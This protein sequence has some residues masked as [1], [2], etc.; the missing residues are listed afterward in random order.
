[1]SQDRPQLDPL[2]LRRFLG[3]SAQLIA[4]MNANPGATSLTDYSGKG[5]PLTP[6][7]V[8]FGGRPLAPGL[9][10]KS[11]RFNGVSSKLYTSVFDTAVP[12]PQSAG[13]TALF[14]INEFFPV[15]TRGCLLNAQGAG[16]EYFRIR[17]F[18]NVGPLVETIYNDGSGEAYGKS[19]EGN[20]TGMPSLIAVR[21]NPDTDELAPVIVS[22]AGEFF[23]PPNVG[24]MSGKLPFSPVNS[25]DFGAQRSGVF[26]S[27]TMNGLAI[28]SRFVTNEELSLI[29]DLSGIKNP[30]ADYKPFYVSDYPTSPRRYFA[31]Y[32]TDY[33]DAIGKPAV[34]VWPKR[35]FGRAT[36]RG[37]LGA[38]DGA[39]VGTASGGDAPSVDDYGRGLSSGSGGQVTVPSDLE[40]NPSSPH[41][42]IAT[43]TA[44]S[45]GFN[46]FKQRIDT[47]EDRV[48]RIVDQGDGSFSA[49][50]VINEGGTNYFVSQEFDG[51]PFLVA[52]GLGADKFPFVKVNSSSRDKAGASTSNFKQPSEVDVILTYLKCER[53]DVV[54][55][56]ADEL[57]DSELD[58]LYEA[59]FDRT[60]RLSKAELDAL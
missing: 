26:F 3:N 34:E 38:H 22:S 51:G 29:A 28:A 25:I 56:V 45:G 40:L 14:F 24:D 55:L 50:T 33:L 49:Q 37:V 57:T 54:A 5:R 13:Y 17:T 44:D 58:H 27:G 10:G 4:W 8:E 59:A 6:A 18:G 15:D 46:Y 20:F 19:Q 9:Y 30:P 31:E 52:H 53:I 32:L 21:F 36:A 11:A 41:T 35:E 16:G 39:F 12:V 1:M 48:Y 7:N 47:S 43:S 60:K 42:V 2:L 23:S